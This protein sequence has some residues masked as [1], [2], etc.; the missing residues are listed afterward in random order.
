MLDNHAILIKEY[1][2]FL[3]EAEE[4]DTMPSNMPAMTQNEQSPVSSQATP[5][6]VTSTPIDA[7][8][9]SWLQKTDNL[10]RLNTRLNAIKAEASI[11]E[12]TTKSPLLKIKPLPGSNE[13]PDWRDKT[14]NIMKDFL[15][16]FEESVLP[17]PADGYTDVMN[18]VQSEAS[19]NL[20]IE[21]NGNSLILCG[22]ADAVATMAATVNDMI[23]D[24]LEEV[25][26]YNQYEKKHVKYL[27]KFSKHEVEKICPP[28]EYEF[29]SSSGL[30]TVTAN[31]KMRT[32]F[33]CVIEN[34]IKGIEEKILELEH[35]V[36]EL[37]KSERGGSLFENVIGYKLCEIVYVFEEDPPSFKLHILSPSQKKAVQKF[38]KHAIK[39]LFVLKKIKMDPGKFRFCNDRK[40]KGKVDYLQ[41]EVLVRVTVDDSS[42]SVA[43]T[44]EEIVVDD[45]ISKLQSFL[46][47]QTCVE[48]QVSIGYHQWYVIDR[49]MS[50]ELAAVNAEVGKDM[51]IHRPKPTEPTEEVSVIIRGE[52]DVVDDVRSKLEG[53]AKKVCY[54]E[55][56][57]RHIPAASKVLDSMKD[58]LYVLQNQYGASIDANVIDDHLGA[59]QN[60]AGLAASRVCSATCSNGVRISVY[61]G[62][63]TKHSHVDAIVVFIPPNPQHLEDSNLKMLFSTGGWDI[64]SDFWAKISELL[65]QD[66]GV[67][68]QSNPGKLKCARLFH[69]ILPP[70]GSTSK[71]KKEEYYLVD[72]LQNFLSTASTYN[73]IIFTSV[74]SSPLKYPAD[75]FAKSV[76]SLVGSSSSLSYD[77][78]VVVYVNDVAHAREFEVQFKENNC[79]VAPP[80]VSAPKV[81]T[82]PASSFLTLTKGDILKQTVSLA[83]SCQYLFL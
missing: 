21:S 65:H 36:F 4:V 74:C 22:N 48:E 45:V 15:S 17:L 68:F 30:I 11:D 24:I 54:K 80:P 73:T 77:L 10:H 3:E 35:D 53:L 62:D 82:R 7:A 6:C 9:S 29:D 2:D 75:I 61:N 16:D 63:F 79:E 18:F 76:L 42:Q 39:K 51:I 55:E 47:E 5:W 13:M 52:P 14:E 56:T 28:V 27:E 57:L 32:H 81:I 33:W 49:D 25:P 46:L 20:F 40:W 58:R 31:K 37:L 70:W 67:V 43:V 60:Q 41:K 64:E 83:F 12:D 50:Q 8:R 23:R 72:C 1:Y 78:T 44:G 19:G 71:N 38:V 69:C 66:H 26:E 59:D 34:E